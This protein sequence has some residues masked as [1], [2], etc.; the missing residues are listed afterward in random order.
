MS[1]GIGIDLSVNANKLTDVRRKILDT[2]SALDDL[3]RRSNLHLEIDAKSNVPNL[4]QE[5]MDTM[6]KLEGINARASKNGGMKIGENDVANRLFEKYRTDAAAYEQAL[7]RIGKGLDA[8]YE[9]KK[10]LE[11]VP[12]TSPDWE[13][14]QE[15]LKSVN[16]DYR[17]H[18]SDY[19]KIQSKYDP[20]ADRARTGVNQVQNDLDGQKILPE[21]GRGGGLGLGKIFGYGAALLGGFSIMSLLHDSMNKAGSYYSSEADFQMRTGKAP[22]GRTLGMGTQYGYAPGDTLGVYDAINRQT[23]LRGGGLGML[24]DQAIKGSRAWGISAESIIGYQGGMFPAS[25]MTPEELKKQTERLQ[26]IAEGI[27]QGGRIEEILRRN[28]DLTVTAAQTLGR[29]LTSKEVSGLTDMQMRLWA[30]GPSGM[31]AL[32]SSALNNLQNAASTGGG[33]QRGRMFMYNAFGGNQ[34]HGVSD[35][36]DVQEKMQGP[37]TSDKASAIFS[38]MRQIPGAYDSK[39]KMTD[40]GALFLTTLGLPVGQARY[41]TSAANGGAFD[42][43]LPEGADMDTHLAKWGKTTGAQHLKTMAEMEGA[44]VNMG[45]IVLPWVDKFRG[46]LPLLYNDIKGEHFLKAVPDFL[47][48]NPIGDLLAAAG[49]LTAADK[50]LSSGGGLAAGAAIGA[51]GLTLLKGASSGA[52]AIGRRG[53]SLLNPVTAGIAAAGYIMSPNNDQVGEDAIV[54]KTNSGANLPQINAEAERLAK[55]NHDTGGGVFEEL[56]SL[57]RELNLFLHELNHDPIRRAPGAQGSTR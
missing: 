29:A 4:V 18:V 19:D 14:A 34:I 12:F 54:R 9:K 24:G 7:G 11:S 48:D 32:G 5:M 17:S 42:Q 22:N 21:G 28:Q 1:D 15:E 57:M 53:L 41:L 55:L 27:G 37:M 25:N 43:A 52:R 23:G 56:L 45:G 26:K 51:G 30:S 20:R 31:G 39:G 49:G 50:L 6:R 10:K 40:Y 35:Y 3:N 8:L 36:L 44:K 46:K 2:S 33:S 47:K 13:K 38:A 16:Q